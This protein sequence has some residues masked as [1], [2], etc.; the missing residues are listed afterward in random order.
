MVHRPQNLDAASSLAFLQEEASQDQFSKKNELGIYT[1]KYNSDQP[2]GSQGGGT[3]N[4]TRS[5]DDRKSP[6]ASRAKSSDDK[7]AALKSFR[8]SKGLCFKCGA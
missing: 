4:I 8:R 3:S 1:K 7:V 2:K 6:E 5:V